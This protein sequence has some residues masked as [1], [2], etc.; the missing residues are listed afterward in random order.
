MKKIAA[1]FFIMLF[2]PFFAG[3][4]G[5]TDILDLSEECGCELRF[6]YWK[7]VYELRKGRAAVRFSSGSPWYLVNMNE[8]RGGIETELTSDGR[9]LIDKDTAADV[10]AFFEQQ[11]PVIGGIR[12]IVLDPGHGGKDPG[13]IGY[14]TS[15]GEKKS[16]QEKDV[17]L[18]TA[19]TAAEMLQARY[20]DK[21]VLLTRGDDRYLKLEER[22]EIANSVELREG[23]SMIFV[24][25][26]ANA[27]FNSTARGF[28]VWY[29]PPEYRRDLLDEDQY[30]SVD[31]DVIPILNTMLEEEYTIESVILGEKLLDALDA[32]VGD[33]S[34]NRGPKEE[35]WFVVRNAHMPSVLIELGFV[36]NQDEAVLLSSPSYLKKLSKGIYNGIV[37]FINDYE[38][39]RGYS[40]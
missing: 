19:L 24:S 31:S 39:T 34:I 12:Y 37:D 14:Y 2:I 4:E 23:E 33:I 29:L 21:E 16:L 36:T 38:R 10:A 17:V 25:V 11:G 9:F 22:T 7:G 28:E 5:F 35:S 15:G 3:A 18:K 32:Q 13:A 8:L 1:V 27:S 40:E 26:H 30:D 20:P 6:D